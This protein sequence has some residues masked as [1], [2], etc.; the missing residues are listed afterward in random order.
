MVCAIYSRM[1]V[2][3]RGAN[4]RARTEPPSYVTVGEFARNGMVV[5]RG[6]VAQCASHA[7]SSLEAWRLAGLCAARSR[8]GTPF[9]F[10]LLPGRQVGTNQALVLFWEDAKDGH[11]WKWVP[12][13]E[14]PTAA[15][16]LEALCLPQFG[17]LDMEVADLTHG[18]P[19]VRLLKRSVQLDSVICKGARRYLVSVVPPALIEPAPTPARR[20]VVVAGEPMHE[21][22]LADAAGG[23]GLPAHFISH[24]SS[25]EGLLP[26]AA[27]GAEAGA[28]EARGRDQGGAEQIAGGAPTRGSK[29]SRE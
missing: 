13:V 15:R 18:L 7:I 3:E 25:G 2:R 11:G 29:R 8:A 21:R 24:E 28:R 6:V 4:G 10:P 12:A 20:D 9:S 14:V 23:H 1:A 5:P 19:R 27:G 22:A 26:P 17:L 16:A